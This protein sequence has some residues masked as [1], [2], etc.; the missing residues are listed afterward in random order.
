MNIEQVIAAARATVEQATAAHMAEHGSD[1]QRN[2]RLDTAWLTLSSIAEIEWH[3]WAENEY[4]SNENG[5]VTGNWN[6]ITDYGPA[7]KDGNRDRNVTVPGGDVMKR[8]AAIFES[9][10]VDV[11]WSDE[12]STCGSCGGLMRTSPDSYHWESE[13][14]VG[15]GEIT[16]TACME[17]EGAWQDELDSIHHSRGELA[18]TTATV[19]PSEYGYKPAVLLTIGWDG[20]HDA[21]RC[22]DELDR[23]GLGYFLQRLQDRQSGCTMLVWVSRD[24]EIPDDLHGDHDVEQYDNGDD[25]NGE[26]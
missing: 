21:G 14:V 4:S 12:H 3:P 6:R 16:C 9:M 26:G 10:G 19:D 25:D 7:D 15:D 8:L 11:E 23:A 13:F 5:A 17:S 22:T 24:D 2:H 18:L 1:P 20:W